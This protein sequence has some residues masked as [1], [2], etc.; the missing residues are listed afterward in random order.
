MNSCRPAS[1]S[2]IWTARLTAA[3]RP[4]IV[5]TTATDDALR[6]L[7]PRPS[8]TSS[9]PGSDA[10]KRARPRIGCDDGGR[11]ATLR[12]S[13][14]RLRRCA[15]ERPL[16]KTRPIQGSSRWPAGRP[17]VLTRVIRE[18]IQSATSVSET[19]R[20]RSPVI[21]TLIGRGRLPGIE[22]PGN[23]PFLAARRRGAP[24]P[25]KPRRLPRAAADHPGTLSRGN[26]SKSAASACQSYSVPA[27]AR[28]SGLVGSASIVVTST[29]ESCSGQI[30]CRRLESN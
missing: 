18:H 13:L 4:F 7:P 28:S 25:P 17:S 26:Q 16:P 11:R 10:L 2:R 5:P 12:A 14:D 1:R 21:L 15:R 19:C 6:L 8:A 23:R 24:R 3:R 22:S 30:G 20:R 29:R 27:W 9:T